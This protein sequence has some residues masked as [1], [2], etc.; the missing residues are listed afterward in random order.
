MLA[1]L[2]FEVRQIGTDLGKLTAQSDFFSIDSSGHAKLFGG[3]KRADQAENQ[4]DR[5]RRQE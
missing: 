4:A 3:S 1:R 2:V 5:T